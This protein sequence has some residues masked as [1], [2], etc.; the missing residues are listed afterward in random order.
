MKKLRVLVTG[1][2]GYIGRHVVKEFALAG[3]EVWAT[4]IQNMLQDWA[5]IERHAKGVFRGIDLRDM[6][7]EMMF[8]N[9][10][11]KGKPPFDAIIHLAARTS[12]AEA[13]HRIRYYY[14]T[15]LVSTA[16]LVELAKK[17][18]V[19]RF[20]FASSAA[21]YPDDGTLADYGTPTSNQGVYATT[22]LMCER[23]INSHYLNGKNKAVSLRLFNVAGVD[24]ELG[25]P[26]VAK[27]FVSI[28]VNSVLT[29][30]PLIVNG[31]GKQVRD[32]VDVKF[33]AKA[34]VRA[35]TDKKLDSAYYNVGT[36]VPTTLEQVIEQVSRVSRKTI[37][38]KRRGKR[39]GDV[40]FS[41]PRA[42][43]GPFFQPDPDLKSII[44][45]ELKWQGLKIHGE[46]YEVK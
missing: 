33:V 26:D 2:Y 21:V 10:K 13:E 1:A 9:S 24:P 42:Y 7:A 11:R 16:N 14:A 38:C 3:H 25:R 40:K 43:D 17:Y 4:D 20:V 30:E 39:K 8:N 23:M 27:G 34:F 15:N 46:V 29:K 31:N 41:C 37:Q 36:G 44:R 19:P 35:A 18:E 32:Y 12:V 45:D 22:K 6:H 5:P 28:A